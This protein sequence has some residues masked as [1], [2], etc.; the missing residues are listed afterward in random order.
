MAGFAILG[1]AAGDSDPESGQ[2]HAINVHPDR[3]AQ[4]VGSV[5]FAAAEQEFIGLGYARAFL[6][7]AKNNERAISFY[8]NRGWLH[9]G[10]TLED[11]RFDPPVAENRHS[12]TFPHSTARA[13]TL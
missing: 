13:A 10:A 3:W 5:L 11:T 1:P 12:R 7:V 6:W 4:G 2:L 8:S 9:D